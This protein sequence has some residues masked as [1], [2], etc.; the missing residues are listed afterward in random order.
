MKKYYEE[1]K[2]LNTKKNLTGVQAME[3][4]KQNG[5][6]L[7]YVQT[8]TEAICMEAVKQNGYALQYVQT[9][10]EAIC[11]EAV[12]QNGCALQYVQKDIFTKHLVE[13]TIDGE[14]FEISKESAKSFKESINNVKL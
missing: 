3:A 9:Q 13:V 6:A 2:R 10:T 4:V 1:W 11:M 5:Y 8:Q 14:Q 7:Q 12:K